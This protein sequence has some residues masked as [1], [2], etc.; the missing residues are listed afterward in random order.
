MARIEEEALRRNIEEFMLAPPNIKHLPSDATSLAEH[1]TQGL[2]APDLQPSF[3]RF[4]NGVNKFSLVRGLAVLINVFGFNNES[5]SNMRDSTN[6]EFYEVII[7]MFQEPPNNGNNISDVEKLEDE[8]YEE[9]DPIL[10]VRQAEQINLHFR[11]WILGP[12]N[13]F[14]KGVTSFIRSTF[15]KNRE[16]QPFDVTLIQEEPP[17][18]FVIAKVA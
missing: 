7:Y 3:E 11:N 17:A 13:T 9:V 6:K 16:R 2:R 10:E 12:D 1:L 14:E 8:F 5:N 18:D 15:D 4:F